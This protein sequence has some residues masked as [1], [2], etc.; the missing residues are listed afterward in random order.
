MLKLNSYIRKNLLKIN[1]KVNIYLFPFGIPSDMIFVYVQITN[2]IK[3]FCK[4]F[5]FI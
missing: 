2:F 1:T 3:F 4:Q 5:D